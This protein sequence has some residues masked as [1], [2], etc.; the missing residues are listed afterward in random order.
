MARLLAKSPCCGSRVLST[1][2]PKSRAPAGTSSS[3]RAASDCFSRFSINV[4]K[5]NPEVWLQRVGSLP[6]RAPAN[7]SIYFERIHV[8]R[9]TQTRRSGKPL[10]VG[11][12]TFQKPLQGGSRRGFDQ[13]MRAKV[14]GA[15]GD[16]RRG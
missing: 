11:Q 9:P 13:K 16:Q 6:L 10:D 5:A 14:I 8:N 12:P 4:F 7:L 2:T 3:G 15:P 1:S